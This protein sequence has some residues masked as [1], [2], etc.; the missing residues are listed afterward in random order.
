ME[1]PIRAPML[2][3]N[4]FA[5]VF[6]MSLVG[7]A[8]EDVLTWVQRTALVFGVVLV[9]GGISTGRRDHRVVSNDS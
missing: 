1:K 2:W 9:S 8:G 4:A 6:G 5:I 7:W 3:R